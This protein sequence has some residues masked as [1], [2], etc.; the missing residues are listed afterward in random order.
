M[1]HKVTHRN[2]GVFE[3]TYE[4]VIKKLLNGVVCALNVFSE[5]NADVECD[6][7]AILREVGE[8]AVES[9]AQIN[10]RRFIGMLYENK[11]CLE[12]GTP[13]ER[14]RFFVNKYL[15]EKYNE[16]FAEGSE[17]KRLTDNRADKTAAAVAEFLDRLS[18]DRDAIKDELGIE[19][20]KL[21][22]FSIGSGDTHNN[23][24]S[25]YVLD[26][27][28]GEHIV[29]KPHS[30]YNDI[31][32]EKI[33]NWFND[34]GAL[35][36]KLKHAKALDRGDYGW[37]T[38]V[39]FAECVDRDA[40]NRYMYRLGCLLFISYLT[41]C[42]DLHVENII[43][44]GEYP[45]VVDTETIFSNTYAF[46]GAT[47]EKLDGWSLAIAR[48][49]FSSLLL[50]FDM[51]TNMKLD[52]ID[53]S[54]ILG[55][56]RKGGQSMAVQT[57]I[58]KGTDEVSFD[59]KTVNID[60]S[61]EK[62]NLAVLDGTPLH[63]GDFIEFVAKGFDD[64]YRTVMNDKKGFTDFIDR[65]PFDR[66]VYRQVLRNTD[67]YARYLLASYH[68]YYINE[69]EERRFVFAHLK[70][71]SDFISD[72]HEKLVRLEIEQLMNDD[73]PCF[74]ARFK[75]YAIYSVYGEEIEGFY[76]KT[77]EEQV[78][79]RIAS[80]N[81][82]DM[83]RQTYFVRSAI[84]GENYDTD[85]NVRF[86]MPEDV[87]AAHD[88]KGK[89]RDI[90]KW[91][92]DF[93]EKY[94]RV[95][96]KTENTPLY[97]CVSPM[98]TRKRLG[99]ETPALYNGGGSALFHI[100]LARLFG[101]G[102]KELA[103]R[104]ADGYGDT[105]GEFIKEYAPPA[106]GIGLYN[107][108]ASR[109]YINHYAYR[110]FGEERY[111]ER[112][113]RLCDEAMERMDEYGEEFDVIGGYSGTAIFALGAWN[114]DKTLTKLYEL[115]KVCGERLYKLYAENK[116]PVQTGLAHGYAGASAAFIMLGKLLGERKYYDIGIEFV[117]KEQALFNPEKDGW[118]DSRCDEY[119]MHH[120]C[121]GSGGILVSRGVAMDY[122][123]EN[124]RELL[125]HDIDICVRHF[126]TDI[127]G[128]SSMQI[129]CHGLAGNLDVALWHARRTKDSVLMD[130]VEKNTEEL[131]N[132]MLER[133]IE[134]ERSAKVLDISFMTGLTGIGY[135]LERYIDDSIPS[136]LAFETM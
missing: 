17:A 46:K 39:G 85:V 84:S 98:D 93:R 132:K 133:G 27:N 108:I 22:K 28:D 88:V 126:N 3:E 113:N 121:Y 16:V 21:N 75:S 19:I 51:I 56:A 118:K 124:D 42:T 15:I 125:Q 50:P 31:L 103:M 18:R 64:A 34:K 99:L 49:V 107:G 115:A 87:T 78:K 61:A 35:S 76:G 120:W 83:Y 58:N 2:M 123:D 82:T 20:R 134:Y 62:H 24:R 114:R 30:V 119:F 11:E 4:P 131:V 47:A 70:G 68:P 110:A 66:G 102:Y 111:L 44:Q 45:I 60:F 109:I 94:H 135:Y 54:G 7:E 112:M 37:Q 105:E 91:I 9:I 117:K 38:F 53:V 96:S 67:L 29:Y 71:K 12:G 55:G 43:A 5:K 77:I 1:A 100:Q 26:I 52:N 13:E 136:V 128:A 92:Y 122:A 48:S 57:I 32:Y 25:V 14:Y 89:A 81:E 79:E 23:G 86:K 10:V 73:I 106:M 72:E 65:T 95:A 74:E 41:G 33:Q 8:S 116:I 63:A 101:D 59:E 69:R 129:L 36:V 6:G 127:S 80:L 97:Y 130:T 40:A 90:I 104:F